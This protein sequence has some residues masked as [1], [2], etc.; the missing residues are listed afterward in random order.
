MKLKCFIKALIT[1]EDLMW[2]YLYG[3][4]LIYFQP[5]I[6]TEANSVLQKANQKPRVPGLFTA[7]YPDAPLAAL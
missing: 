3:S 7:I 1:R 6:L 5:L 4:C 2:N